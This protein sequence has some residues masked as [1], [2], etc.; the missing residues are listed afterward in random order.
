MRIFRTL[1]KR[2]TKTT[3]LPINRYN[4]SQN[5]K[6]DEYTSFGFKNVK[7]EDRQNLVNS[8]FH[9]VAGK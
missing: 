8:V 6:D 7:K 4:F 3:F 1:V 5:L 9:S 2:S